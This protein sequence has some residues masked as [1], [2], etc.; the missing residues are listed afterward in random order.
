MVLK[1]MA[2]EEESQ[3]LSGLFSVIFDYADAKII[4]YTE[5]CDTS[6][7]EYLGFGSF[8][9]AE[10]IIGGEIVAR[11]DVRC[12]PHKNGYRMEKRFGEAKGCI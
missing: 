1:L 2:G 4:V 9:V 3:F 6:R 7:R 12:N 8:S 11:M 5:D 10:L